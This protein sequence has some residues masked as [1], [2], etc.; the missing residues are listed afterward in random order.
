MLLLVGQLGYE[1]VMK[2][3]FFS[4]EPFEQLLYEQY[5]S[6]DIRILRDL[7]GDVKVS[8]SI[9]NL[10]FNADIYF[11]WWA[12]GSIVPLVVG[13]LRNKPVVVVVGGNEALLTRDSINGEYFG[14][15]SFGFIKKAIVDFVLRYSDRLVA[16]SEFSREELQKVTSSDVSMI[17]NAVDLDDF[18]E[19]VF[20][21][22]QH[23]CR[24]ITVCRLDDKPVRIKRLEN[25]LKAFAVLKLSC[26][27]AILSIVGERGSA[28]PALLDIVERLSLA[29]NVRFLG[30]VPNANMSALLKCHDCYVQLSDVETFGVAV[31]E[32]AATLLPLILSRRGALVEVSN[33]YAVFVDHNEIRDIA[34]AFSK[35]CNGEYPFVLSKRLDLRRFVHEN[36]SYNARALKIEN[37]ING[38]LESG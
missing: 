6:I 32:A 29:N 33:E 17:Y 7:Y 8:N 26:P 28:Y 24:F 14:Y 9:F 20:A 21:D 4:K 5:T 35:F 31:V 12:T 25:I 3:N 34:S 23:E 15:G 22:S 36:F 18:D 38:V 10:S 19:K 37:L 16:V 30:K 11:S 27:E 13:L 2:V 1:D